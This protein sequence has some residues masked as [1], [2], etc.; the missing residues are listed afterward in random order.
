MLG[1]HAEQGQGRVMTAP[2]TGQADRPV[3][4]QDSQAAGRYV[5]F[6]REDGTLKAAW[7]LRAAAGSFGTGGLTS[8]S[9]VCSKTALVLPRRIGLLDFHL[10]HTSSRHS[11][12][13][14]RRPGIHGGVAGG[15]IAFK[16][17]AVFPGRVRLGSLWP[18]NRGGALH[19]QD[20]QCQMCCCRIWCLWRD[21]SGMS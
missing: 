10:G 7:A 14:T 3:A 1:G 9:L 21:D 6:G 12:C 5:E 11:H 17:I 13:D 20:Q 8:W 15:S 18:P 4:S 2:E 16:L 19:S